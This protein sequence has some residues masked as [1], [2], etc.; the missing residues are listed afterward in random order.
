M[1]K[2]RIHLECESSNLRLEPDE[3][4]VGDFVPENRLQDH[5]EVGPYVIA[6][7]KYIEL[8]VDY[9]RSEFGERHSKQR[10]KF[11]YCLIQGT[12]SF[13]QKIMM[14]AWRRIE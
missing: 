11:E 6:I 1:T 10:M 12:D 13:N 2:K 4:A 8:F 7:R 3:C 14:R 5:E 9:E